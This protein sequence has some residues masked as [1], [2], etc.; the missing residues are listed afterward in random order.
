M[1]GPVEV[2]VSPTAR[3]FI[4]HDLA[5]M[6]VP[7]LILE[8]AS[9]TRADRL[10]FVVPK[11]LQIHDYFL[12]PGLKKPAPVV[13]IPDVPQEDITEAL[14]LISR[15]TKESGDE[16]YLSPDADSRRRLV[17]AHAKGAETELIASARVLDGE[18]QVWSCEPRVYR[19]KVTEIPALAEMDPKKLQEFTISASGSR[20]H[21]E[22]GDVD[23]D[24][25]AIRTFSDAKLRRQRQRKAR[26][27]AKQYCDKIRAFRRKNGLGQRDIPGL[28]A[29]QVRRIEAGTS[30]PQLGTLEKLASAHGMSVPDYMSA[31]AKTR[32]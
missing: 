30:V 9:T 31:V 18:L 27:Y 3:P 11:D 24:L 1:T 4:E 2:V 17:F 7:L 12:V 16:L 26:E 25:D 22:A 23:L 8:Q 15:G 14:E 28:T 19:C 29:R 13:L 32:S 10:V 6:S 20:I 21:W 5:G